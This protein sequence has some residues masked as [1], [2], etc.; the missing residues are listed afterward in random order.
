M[1]KRIIIAL[2]FC[3]P[4]QA[5]QHLRTYMQR[6][7][8]YSAVLAAKVPCDRRVVARI[9]AGATKVG[10][11]LVLADSMVRAEASINLHTSPLIEDMKRYKTTNTKWHEGDLY[12]HS[13]W[14]ARCIEQWFDESSEWVEGLSKKDKV[15]MVLAGF[16]HDIG[17]AGDQEFVFYDK[18]RHPRTG[19]D[20]LAEKVPFRVSQTSF[21][22]FNKFFNGVD[23]SPEERKIIAILAG[24]HW[25]FG[26]CL[27][28]LHNHRKESG[29]YRRFFEKL[30]TLV[31]EANYNNGVIDKKLVVMAT[32]IGAADIKGAKKV[33]GCCQTLGLPACDGTHGHAA[34]DMYTRF[35]YEYRG[36]TVR[37][38]LLAYFDRFTVA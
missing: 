30:Q 17:K 8:L 6:A 28:E 7:A 1:M 22:D 36:K 12:E 21:F 25:D 20:Y 10:V 34:E 5:M 19:F 16:L 11:G 13:V 27:R 4:L 29:V 38:K 37:K 14:V 2:M 9:V 32:L 24:I 33:P 26:N 3:V 18:P 23:L 15:V 31:K 35:G